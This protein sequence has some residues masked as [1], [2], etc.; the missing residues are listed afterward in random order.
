MSIVVRCSD[1]GA[2]LKFRD[3]ALGKRA[4]CTKC[5]GVVQVVPGGESRKSDGDDGEAFLNNLADAAVTAS[6]SALYSVIRDPHA[7]SAVTTTP[8]SVEDPAFSETRLGGRL[9]VRIVAFV[10]LLLP[11]VFASRLSLPERLL[12]CITPLML[13][14]TF[15]T[16]AI[17]G[18]RFT[19]RLFIAFIPIVSHR[20]SLRGVTFIKVKFAWEGSGLG[21]I[22]MFGPFQWALGW[23]LDFLIPSVGGPYQIHLV[24]AK[25]RELVAWQGFVDSQFHSTRDLL[26]RL[27]NAEVRSM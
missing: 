1:C 22:L 26:V 4:R 9:R 21:T 12:A 11:L 3:D 10:L 7:V 27:T 2:L 20:C 19:T 6:Q 24:T 25:G 18:D 16:S 5:R 8:D 17:R 23:L 14:G 15:R 13:A